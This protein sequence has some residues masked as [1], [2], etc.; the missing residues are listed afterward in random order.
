[1]SRLVWL[2][3][4]VGIAAIALVV[5]FRGE[6]AAAFRDQAAGGSPTCTSTDSF[7]PAFCLNVPTSSVRHETTVPLVTLPS[8]RADVRVEVT[9]PGSDAAALAVGVDRSVERVEALFGRT[10][11]T[12]PRVLIFGGVASFATGAK[13][14]FGYSRETADHVANTYGGIFDRP[15][16]T[17]AVNWGASGT[18]RMNA[19]I[20]H[21]LT[22]LMI[23]EVTGADSVPAWLD[24]GVATL[25]EQEAPGASTWNAEEELV[26]MAVAASGTVS[27]AQLESVADFHAAYA[28]L[29]RPLYAFA[30]DAVRTMRSRVGWPGVVRVLAALGTGESAATAYQAEAGESLAVMERRLDASASPQ[31]VATTTKDANGNLHWTLYAGRASSDVRVSITGTTDYRV[32]FTVQ[33]DAFGLYR[34]SFG[35]TAAAGTYTVRAGGAA[36]TFA[37]GR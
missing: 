19:A 35:S 15:T 30:A 11:T 12:R 10:F 26:G 17:I 21:E 25:V 13:D 33:T 34:G 29:D 6:A 24:E 36:A 16:L 1:M 28:R 8:Q 27:L 32:S 3:G 5:I 4:T 2:L 22:H 23:R 31:I 14:L 18:T 9:V 7:V 37:T 20:A